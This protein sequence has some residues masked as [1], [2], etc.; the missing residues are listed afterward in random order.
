MKSIALLIT[1]ISCSNTFAQVQQV[2]HIDSLEAS[3]Q[4]DS[5]KQMYPNVI[6]VPEKFECA[7]YKAVSYFPELKKTHIKFTRKRIG[8]TLNCRPTL[9]SL[10]F[11]VKENR[12]YVIRLNNDPTSDAVK[13]KEVSFNAKIG[14][15]GHEIAHVQDYNK[16]TIAGVIKRAGDYLSNQRKAKFEKEI[17]KNTILVGLGWQAYDWAYYMHYLSNIPQEYRK[18]K[19]NTYLGPEEIKSIIETTSQK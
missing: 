10:L 17:D 9:G 1:L 13:I 7:F 14:V 16:R 12:R 5:I 8:T 15:F 11:R 18:F 6:G 19:E 3:M 4:L 2:R